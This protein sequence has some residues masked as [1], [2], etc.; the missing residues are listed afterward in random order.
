MPQHRGPG[1][2]DTRENPQSGSGASRMDGDRR[3]SR[4]GGMFDVLLGAAIDLNGTPDYVHSG[5][6]LISD[7][8][9]V[10]IGLMIAVFVL[11]IFLPFPGSKR[12]DK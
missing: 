8:N 10:V 11:A 6:F 5:W 3:S 2:F 12:R 7:A 9:L 1:D 4:L